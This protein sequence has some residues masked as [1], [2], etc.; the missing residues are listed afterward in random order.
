MGKWRVKR[1]VAKGHSLSGRLIQNIE[2]WAAILAKHRATF[3]IGARRFMT[4]AP[5][6]LRV[7][8]IVLGTAPVTP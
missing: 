7:P 5:T 1:P 6:A 3:G 2:G 4:A 8:S